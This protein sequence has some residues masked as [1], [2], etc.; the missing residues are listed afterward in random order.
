LFSPA[1]CKESAIVVSALAQEDSNC[2]FDSQYSNF[3]NTVDIS[4]PG[5]SITVPIISPYNEVSKNQYY[6][7]SGTSF[8][9]PHV[10]AAVA[11]LCIDKIY[12]INGEPA[13]TS[14]AI[15]KRLLG[16]TLDLGEEGKDIYYG[17]GMLNLTNHGNFLSYKVND[18]DVVYDGQYH[19][20]IV[21]VTD[22]ESYTLKFGLSLKEYNIVDIAEND[23]F[24][25]FTNGEKNIYFEI[26]S[27]SLNTVY[28]VAKLNIRQAQLTATLNNQE[29]IYG[30]KPNLNQYAYTITSGL[31]AGDDPKMRLTTDATE[32]SSVG[33]Y[34][35]FAEIE[36]PNYIMTDLT[37]NYRIK[38]R[39]VKIVLNQQNIA[40]SFDIKL[41][42][43][44][45]KVIEGSVV[46]GDDLN[47][48]VYSTESMSGLVGSYEIT[49]E[50]NNENYIVTVING[51]A[52]I[53][54][55]IISFLIIFIPISLILV[56][57]ATFFFIKRKRNKNKY[58]NEG[59]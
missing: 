36:N 26:S 40:F 7:D 20:N 11:L 5:T 3:G 39:E 57:A 30:E 48:K 55:S 25:N 24:K 12:Y 54:F 50:S 58:L 18:C 4:A 32:K 34:N 59:I 16:C 37:G 29:G 13:Y 15:E 22:T 9:S 14:E 35:I 45:F 52:V 21:N 42:T 56:L 53:E 19:N 46:N 23:L 33:N 10:A 8:A 51:T 31:V 49:A 1:G 44:D 38:P 27:P 6:I 47:L 41:D 28:G 17:N 2:Y 43:D